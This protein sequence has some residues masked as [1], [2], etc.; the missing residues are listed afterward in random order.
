MAG[1]WKRVLSRDTTTNLTKRSVGGL[2]RGKRGVTQRIAEIILILRQLVA[3][4]SLHLVYTPGLPQ[5]L[6]LEQ[7]NWL[8]PRHRRDGVPAAAPAARHTSWE[9]INSAQCS[10][11]YF[12]GSFGRGDH[13]CSGRSVGISK[14]TRWMVFGHKVRSV[15][16]KWTRSGRG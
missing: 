16:V 9:T 10:A 4:K 14:E 12:E 1:V 6:E 5:D 8:L 11:P 15:D 13:S 2:E 3:N 7:H